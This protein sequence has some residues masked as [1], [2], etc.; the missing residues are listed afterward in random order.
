M[1][2]AMRRTSAIV[3]LSKLHHDILIP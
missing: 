2:S 1:A 3:S